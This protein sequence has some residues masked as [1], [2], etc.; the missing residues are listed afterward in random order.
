MKTTLK[1]FA[2]LVATLSF[3]SASQAGVVIDATFDGTNTV[4]GISGVMGTPTGLDTN[5]DGSNNLFFININPGSFTF[6]NP[7]ATITNLGITSSI[8]P[9]NNS[10]S[11]AWIAN[12]GHP[13]VAI[14][15]LDG[16]QFRFD[17]GSTFTGDLEVS[18]P[19]DHSNFDGVTF[20]DQDGTLIQAVPEPASGTLLGLCA[21]GLLTRRQ[22]G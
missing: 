16:I 11:I 6:D 5:G 17:S 14:G 13:S 3:V 2:A 8:A 22:R 19:G 18:I 21:L 20:N 10:S 1:A 4:L 12:S 7:N 9:G 15:D